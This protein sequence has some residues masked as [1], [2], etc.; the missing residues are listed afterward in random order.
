[1]CGCHLNNDSY[2]F[3]SCE[4]KKFI[5]EEEAN[6]MKLKMVCLSSFK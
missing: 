2:S 5:D 6:K 4:W 1:M 3:T